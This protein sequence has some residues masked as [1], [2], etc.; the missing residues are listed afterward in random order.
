MKQT[1]ELFLLIGGVVLVA[2]LAA[3]GAYIY[4]N[5]KAGKK[6]GRKQKPLDP[7]IQNLKRIRDQLG[8]DFDPNDPNDPLAAI[9]A[10]GEYFRAPG[11]EPGGPHF[12]ETLRRVLDMVEGMVP[13]ARLAFWQEQVH[14]LYGSR[15]SSR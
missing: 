1:T 5:W 8:L 13:P 9:I 4:E 14:R 11:C 6:K 2:I 10:A 12:E 3:V 7:S 15:P